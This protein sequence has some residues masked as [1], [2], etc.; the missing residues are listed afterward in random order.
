MN[1]NIL[2]DRICIQQLEELKLVGFRVL[3]DADQYI[4]EIL[5]ASLSLKDRIMDIKHVISPD[6]QIGAFMVDAD[7]ENEDGYWVCVQVDKYEDIPKD[8]TSLTV[9]QQTYA[10]IT[11]EGSNHDIRKSYEKLHEW[12]MKNN[13]TRSL[14]KW[15]IERFLDYKNKDQ[16][17]VQLF[18]T[19]L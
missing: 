6:Q 7:S 13:Y 3:C 12:I 17:K 14:N 4:N 1:G 10:M 5:K 18:D 19:I 16:L 15:H 8:M 11:H 9:P 2:Q